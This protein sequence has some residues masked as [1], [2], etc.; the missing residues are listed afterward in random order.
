[1]SR[2][3][4]VSVIGDTHMESGGT[5]WNLVE[6]LA[7]KLT[8]SGYRIMTGGLGDLPKAIAKGARKSSKYTDGT[9]IAILPGFDPS[10]AEDY[11]D[12]A[13]ATGM[14]QAR[15]LIVSNG[16]AI[17][18]IGGG[19][20]TLSEIA[21]AWS[22]KRLIIAFNQPGWSKALANSRIDQRNRYPD[23]PEDR[24]F[25]AVTCDDA[26]KKLGQY[27]QK[28]NKRHTTTRVKNKVR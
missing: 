11:A 18:A 27:L 22:L 1:L 24:V 5:K 4:I 12:I 25:E 8:N 21:Y 3:P 2:R 17:I 9:L 13:I 16:D 15:N 10:L 7:E 26:L 23:I 20:G 14:D 19:A 6:E 28:Y